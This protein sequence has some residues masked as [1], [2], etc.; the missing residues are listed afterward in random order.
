M[1]KL[2]LYLLSLQFIFSIFLR[3]DTLK[4]TFSSNPYQIITED[5]FHII[6]MDNFGLYG[7][8]GDPL[9]PL[10]TYNIALPPFTDFTKVSIDIDNYD[11]QE[12]EGTYEIK[13]A[14]PWT[15]GKNIYWGENKNIINGKN[16][17][18]YG[19]DE[20]YPKNFIF[21]EDASHQMRKWKFITIYYFPFQYNPIRKKLYLI[22]SV[23]ISINF[24]SL[25]S[26]QLYTLGSETQLFTLLNDKV[27][28]REAGMIIYNYNQAKI[29]YENEK[30][31]L[32]N[33]LE[34][35]G[36]T[37]ATLNS[38]TFDYVIIT[39][40]YIVQNSTKLSDFKNHLEKLGHSVKIITENDFNL[41]SG[42][43]RAD[44]IRNWLKSYYVNY[45]IEYVLLI[46]D[47]DPK[48]PDNPNDIVGDIPMKMCFPDYS[49]FRGTR[50]DIP[51]DYYYA[52]LTG[53]WDLNGD[54]HYGDG[55]S[56]GFGDYGEGGVDLYPEVYVGRIPVYNNDVVGLDKILQKTIDYEKIG[57]KDISWRKKMLLP[58]AILNYENQHYLGEP[59]TDGRELPKYVIE[60][61][62]QPHNFEW[63]VFYEKDGF[64]H[65]PDDASYD[66]PYHIGISETNLINEWENGYGLVFW[67]AHGSK[68]EVAREIWKGDGNNNGIPEKNEID[69]KLLFK[70]D[71]TSQL[72]DTKPSVVFQNSCLNG[73]PEYEGDPLGMGEIGEP[74]GYALLKNGAIATISASRETLYLTGTWPTTFNWAENRNIGY[75]FFWYFILPPPWPISQAFYISKYNLADGSNDADRI[76]SW[77]NKFAYNL[78]GEP[79]LPFTEI[80]FNQPPMNPQNISPSNGQTHLSLTPT[81]KSSQFND[82]E[83]R[84]HLSTQWQITTI[85]G[86]YTSPIYDITTEDYLEQITIPS[87]VL[88]WGKTY[89]WRVRYSDCYEV[90]SDWSEEASFTTNYPPSKPENKNPANGQKGVSLTP[91]LTSS[92]Y[93]DPENDSHSAT[94]WVIKNASGNIIWSQTT[95]ASTSIQVPSGILS[96]GTTYYWQVR[97]KDSFGAWSEWSTPTSFTTNSL[98][99]T[100]QNIS[101]PDGATGVSLTPTLTASSFSDPDGDSFSA[102]HW[103]IRKD[104]NDWSRATWDYISSPLTSIPVSSEVLDYSTK[105]WWRV[106][107]KDSNGAWSNWSTETSFTT[108]EE[109]SG[110]GG[111]GGG[112]G[113]FIASVCF[114]E[115]SW[116]VKIFK[117]FRD[118]YLVKHKL[119]EKFIGLYYKYSPSVADFLRSHRYLIPPVKA[120]L[121][122]VLV[123][124][125]LFKY[126]AYLLLILATPLLMKKLIILIKLR[127]I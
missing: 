67:S 2:I 52:D 75:Y 107:Y 127:K 46:G 61:I 102:S 70:N 55:D 86:D 122:F 108:Q 65:V 7:S 38:Q 111:G 83:G 11:I 44:K 29:W 17:N 53:N 21:K 56:Y 96:Y 105:Y 104:G 110:G 43:E 14:P 47:P 60:N 106:S 45:G 74:L 59:K 28:D 22:K 115:S 62:L 16:M 124:I 23:E 54:N 31:N 40:Q 69:W 118:R 125:S 64:S 89:Y 37:L 90:W 19:K 85:S 1:K 27:I 34:Q 78:Y 71:D 18:V 97:Y 82:P 68:Q 73:Y 81:L 20:L 49:T 119:G 36:Q 112:G 123:S 5:N 88:N 50:V 24:E 33:K 109:P 84:P 93:S 6:K 25:S 26:S 39:T 9:L 98:P 91:T 72:D 66:N 99:N 8:P 4:F 95:T 41:M 35:S 79:S 114:G 80:I 113:C 103:Q 30:N 116:Q 12:I 76:S 51:T 58:M 48:D 117:N 92:S 15:D 87:G 94:E 13:P 121:Y 126:W 57:D 63:Y 101:P 10:K 77:R 100:P 42:I 120:I 32:K 3:A